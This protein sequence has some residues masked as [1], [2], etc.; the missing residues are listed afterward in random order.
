MDSRQVIEQLLATE[1][2]L[3]FRRFYVN[4]P[5]RGLHHGI[6]DRGSHIKR[7]DVRVIVFGDSFNVRYGLSGGRGKIRREQDIA[8]SYSGFGDCGV[9]AVVLLSPFLVQ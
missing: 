7:D 2:V 4:W 8:K 3:R 6:Y 1:S 9:H 5:C